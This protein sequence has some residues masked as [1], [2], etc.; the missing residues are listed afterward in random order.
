MF[1]FS[2][3][4]MF[5]G[6][7]GN[8]FI[9]IMCSN[10]ELHPQIILPVLSFFPSF[11][12]SYP[13]FLPYFLFVMIPE[14]QREGWDKRCL[15]N[16]ELCCL[17]FY[18]YMYQL[19]VSVNLHLQQKEASLILIIFI[20]HLPEIF[21]NDIPVYWKISFLPLMHTIIYMLFDLVFF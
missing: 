13:S 10:T 5:W 20:K 3:L 21:W 11:L 18:L 19:L 9:L 17:P 15:L 12:L 6:Y 8:L 4:W 2:T 7:N 1:Y 14:A 16:W